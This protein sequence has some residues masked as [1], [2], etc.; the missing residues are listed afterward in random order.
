MKKSFIAFL[1]TLSLSLPITAQISIVSDKKSKSVYVDKKGII[2][3]ADG[4]ELALFGANYSLPSACD[5][6]AAGLVSTD[7]K[8][9]VNE[10]ITHFAR[11]GWDGM[12][13]CLWGDYE[14]SDKDGNLIENDHLNIMD[15]AIY[16]AKER[17]IFILLTPITTYS[18]QWPDIMND[19]ISARGFSTFYKKSE[20]GINTKAI[21]VQVNYLKQVMNHVNP[22]TGVALKDEPAIL[23]VE[24]INEPTHHPDDFQGS[25]SYINSLANAVRDTGCKKLLFYNVSQDMNIAKAIKASKA[26][27]ASFAWYPMG[28]TSGRIRSENHLRAVDD[29]TPMH[30]PDLAGKPK[31]VYEFDEA[32]G[33]SP[34]MYPAMVRS[35]RAVGAQFVSMFSYDMLE[36]APYNLGWQS[37]VFNMVYYPQKAVGGIIAAEEMKHLPL[38]KSYG[39][40]PQNTTFGPVRIN[41]E[42]NSSELL[43]KEKFMYSNNTATKPADVKSLKQIVGYGSSPLV[44]YPGKGLYFLDK[45][46][47]GLWRL[48][49][50]PDAIILSDPFA[51]MSKDK[52]VSRLINRE[53]PMEI[54]IPDLGSSFFVSPVNDGNSYISTTNSGKFSIRPGVYILS[55][56]AKPDNLPKNI[57]N[58]KFDEFVCPAPATLPTTV[59]NKS[60]EEYQSGNNI[61]LHADIID[62]HSPDAVN[63]YYRSAKQSKGFRMIAM[64]NTG[65]YSYEATLPAEHLQ[66]G[67]YKYAICVTLN[68]KTKTYPAETDKKPTD[69]DF[70]SSNQWEFSVVNKRAELSLLNPDKD[71]ANISYTRIGDGG[72]TGNYTL[73]PATDLGRTAIRF[74]FPLKDNPT[75]EDYTM[76]IPVKSRILSRV[77]NLKDASS[78]ILRLRGELKDQKAFV[79]IMEADGTSWSTE[80]TVEKDWNTLTIP[81]NKLQS[82]KGI[83]LPQGFPGEWDYWVNPALGRGVAG[84]RPQLNKIERVQISFRP[85]GNSVAGDNPW[86]D[87]STVN[88]TFN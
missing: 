3:W 35:F 28:L 57:G 59:L 71:Y 21:K 65:G 20:L 67:I 49:V 24:L 52:V 50:Y 25:V 81:L 74:Y 84:D 72:R 62:S 47:N 1:V 78:I 37:H 27:G 64:K 85:S 15:Y 34:Y 75:L 51:Q 46:E 12:R 87:L 88:I 44:S 5:Y 83:L 8:K 43:T 16:K 22:Y 2:R 23:F 60:F 36:T 70:Y 38:Y 33:Y 45:V 10:D 48:E 39:N 11:M 69:W 19:T 26:D 13:L 54:S 58:V 4:R 18:S 82:G 80:I 63:L 77:E 66:E 56:K 29:F 31:I 9:M 42:E 68:G 76:S 61:T 41:Y 40:Y 32:D 30:T 6:R 73:V 7:K 86:L 14:N 79:T 55:V 53:W 17:G